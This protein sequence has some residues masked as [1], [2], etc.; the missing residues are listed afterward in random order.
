MFKKIVCLIL[1]VNILSC[2]DNTKESKD[3]QETKNTVIDKES[4][5]K[6]ANHYY[7]E[8]MFLEG[9]QAFDSL[10]AVDSSK[11]GYYFK[12]GFCKMM[13][14]RDDQGAVADYTKS[15]E[16]NYIGKS[17]SYLNIG[18]IYRRN[19]QFDSALYFY[20]KCLDISP[21]DSEAI[22]GLRAINNSLKKH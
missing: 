10:I 16:K 20:N 14:Q 12:R 2:D 21:N 4:M 5:A 15:I 8:N 7:E 22:K 17:S 1:L 3:T 6:K 19:K 18:V 11:A 13:L 9:K